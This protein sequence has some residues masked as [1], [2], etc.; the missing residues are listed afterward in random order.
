[1][2]QESWKDEDPTFTV[3]CDNCDETLGPYRTEAVAI[4]SAIE[5][6]WVVRSPKQ[7]FSGIVYNE[8]CPKC[9]WESKYA[10]HHKRD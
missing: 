7:K 9:K 3:T 4:V 8:F 10:D 5:A 6:C 2:I 1:M